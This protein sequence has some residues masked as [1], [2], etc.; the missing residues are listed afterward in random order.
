MS[1]GAVDA[2]TCSQRLLKARENIDKLLVSTK[3]QEFVDRMIESLPRLGAPN[4]T[5]KVA[6]S[7]DVKA[8]C[9]SSVSSL[10]LTADEAWA[11]AVRFE[12]C[13]LRVPGDETK[14]LHV[15]ND[16]AQKLVGMD[17]PRRSLAIAKELA[18]LTTNLPTAWDT[19]IFLRV[20]DERVDLI[21]AL[22]V[23]PKDTPYE[24]GCFIFDIFLPH[25]Y[26]QTS[27]L[28]KSMTTNGGRYRYNPNLYA[29]GKV[30]LS[31]LGTVSGACL[32]QR[33]GWILTVSGL[34]LAGSRASRRCSRFSSRSRV[35]F[36]AT[37]LTATSLGGLGR[38]VRKRARCTLPTSGAWCLS[39]P[40]P[41]ISRRLR[42]LVSNIPKNQLTSV[43]AEIKEHFRLKADAI[44]AQLDAW[45]V[46]D[47]DKPTAGEPSDFSMRSGTDF[48]KAATELRKLLDELSPP[49]PAPAPAPRRNPSRATRKA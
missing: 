44:R 29:D 27:P 8:V 2:L 49:A 40:W 23:G 26:N 25:S 11:T 36:C 33:L 31:L 9:E 17:I 24:N 19:S 10:R 34:V 38:R 6:P 16:Q 32:S 48:G 37:S 14:F 42:S 43:E 30:C 22:I 18:I 21:K 3:G 15:Y 35:S 5:S 12:Y 7:D 4:G 45:K 20:D 13:S 1:H 28:V 39:T 41:T 46:L 47:D